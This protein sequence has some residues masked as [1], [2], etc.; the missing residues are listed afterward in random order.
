MKHIP[1]ERLTE[2]RGEPVYD[3]EGEKIGSVEEIFYDKQTGQPEWVGIGTGFFGTKRV[4]VPVAGARATDEGL[5]VRYSKDQVKDSPDIDEDEISPERE[6]ELYSYYGLEPSRRR[7][8][9]RARTSGRRR[10]S[11]SVTRTE[12]ELHVGKERVET[13][14]V[15]LRKWVETEQVNVP[16][17]L[18]KEKVA[19]ER[20]PLD[21][22]AS[23][24]EMGD[25]DVEV[26]VSEERPVVEKRAVAKER[27]TVDKDVETQRETVGGEVRRERVDVDDSTR[28]TPRR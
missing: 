8:G 13:G 21:R 24:A 2:L 27:I 3:A 11:A 4:L 9:H 18:R 28:Q 12:E 10:D 7:S 14:G 20:Q 22:E 19:V 15:R 5:S 6:Y 17:E 23:P 1:L 25:E 26:T 16:V